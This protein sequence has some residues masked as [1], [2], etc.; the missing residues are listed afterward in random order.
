MSRP[1]RS[2]S[3]Q[4]TAA[5]RGAGEAAS[6][7][8][9]ASPPSR[10]MPMPGN[11]SWALPWPRASVGRPPDSM[12]QNHAAMCQPGGSL[13]WHSRACRRSEA[14]GSC[15]VRVEVRPMNATGTGSTGPALICGA[16]CWHAHCSSSLIAAFWRASYARGGRAGD[17]PDFPP[18]FQPARCFTVIHIICVNSAIGNMGRRITGVFFAFLVA[19][20]WCCAHDNFSGP[21]IALTCGDDD[22]TCARRIGIRAFLLRWCAFVPVGRE[23]AWRSAGFLPDRRRVPGRRRDS[24]GWR[25][26]HHEVTRAC[27]RP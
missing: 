12:S 19:V 18:D 11:C 26:R 4:M 27:E 25:L 17:D 21:D 14:A 23:A 5:N 8:R 15:N 24:Q 16:G 6:A 2:M 9:S 10:G 3:S 13:A 22:V 7:S 20:S 1:E